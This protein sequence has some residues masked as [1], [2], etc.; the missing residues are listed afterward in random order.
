LLFVIPKLLSRLAIIA[1][2]LL[3]G[4]AA[5]INL[6]FITSGLC[7]LTSDSQN[8]IYSKEQLVGAG[9]VTRDFSV[10]S[11][12]QEQLST[13]LTK[14]GVDPSSLD[15][16]MISHLRE[17]TP[18]FSVITWLFVVLLIATLVV[19]LVA[20]IMSGKRRVATILRQ[21]GIATLLIFLALAIWIIVDFN[22]LFVTMHQILFA[23]G[24]WTFSSTSLLIC[25]YPTD[26]WIGM[27]VIWIALSAILSAI[28]IALSI[29]LNR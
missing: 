23:D 22:G 1:M 16:N 27:G 11:I 15:T 14:I 21:C 20:A 4:L 29:V 8:S 19:L 17:C 26:F 28:F 13:E 25:M 7:N 24:N 10:G 2:L 12:S 6:P 18:I 3:S 5:C 9:V